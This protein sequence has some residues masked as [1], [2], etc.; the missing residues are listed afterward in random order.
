LLACWL[1]LVN[2]SSGYTELMKAML[3]VDPS[4]RPTVA[5]VLERVEALQRGDTSPSSVPAT[6][7]TATSSTSTTA[8]VGGDIADAFR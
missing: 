6:T 2:S 5:Q 7:A 1:A 4:L 3:Q 8:F